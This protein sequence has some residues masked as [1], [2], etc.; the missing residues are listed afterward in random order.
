[1]YGEETDIQTGEKSP[2]T[3]NKS[4]VV[5]FVLQDNGFVC[6]R[7]SGTEPKIKL[8]ISVSDKDEATASARIEQIE[9][10]MKKMFD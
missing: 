3:L 6:V 8:Y 9:A 5:Y 1:M 2:V 4:D 10:E 7:P